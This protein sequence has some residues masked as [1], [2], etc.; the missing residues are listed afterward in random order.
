MDL[1]D[2]R[3]SMI[4]FIEAFALISYSPAFSVSFSSR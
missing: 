4:S 3:R 1:P 2:F